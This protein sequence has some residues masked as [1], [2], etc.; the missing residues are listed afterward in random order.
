M[1]IFAIAFI[2]TLN[3]PD[4]LNFELAEED[5]HRLTSETQPT[6]SG[7]TKAKTLPVPNLLQG[8]SKSV[9]SPP[10]VIVSPAT[11]LP[12]GGTANRGEFF[13]HVANALVSL[14]AGDGGRP[15]FRKKLN[16][17][18]SRV[19][20]PPLPR[21]E[22]PKQ[23]NY[24]PGSSPPRSRKRKTPVNDKMFADAKWTAEKQQFGV[25]GGLINAV[26]SAETSGKLTDYQWVGTLGMVISQS[27]QLTVAY[28][29]LER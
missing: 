23:D 19:H 15:Q 11:E 14:N 3:L 1:L 17:P 18:P 24:G 29:R 28:G 6:P 26:N 10:T 27:S 7:P 13:S 22:P 8:L 9:S 2:A 12:P 16:Q 21:V 20:S 25:N 5:V 4:T